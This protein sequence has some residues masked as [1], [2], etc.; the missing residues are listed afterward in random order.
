MELPLAQKKV[1][2]AWLRASVI[3]SLWASVE[4]ILGSFFHNIRI[5]FAGTILVFLPR[6]VV[7]GFRELVEPVFGKGCLLELETRKTGCLRLDR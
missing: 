1:S 3:G 2:E 6:Q 5:P 7:T 4:I